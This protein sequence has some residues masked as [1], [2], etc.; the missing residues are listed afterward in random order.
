MEI[1]TTLTRVTLRPMSGDRHR[2]VRLQREYY[3]RTSAGYDDLH[4]AE[5]EPGLELV[6]DCLQRWKAASVLDV[7]TGTGRLLRELAA[8]EPAVAFHG[9]DPVTE[10]LEIAHERYGLPASA[11]SVAG[12]ERLPFDDGSWDAVC[13][14]GVLH[15]VPQPGVVVAEMLRVAAR[16]VVICDDNRFAV[17]ALPRRLAKVALARV[18]VLDRAA[19]VRHGGRDYRFSE[20]DGVSYGFSV[21]DVIAPVREWADE[22]IIHPVGG[23]RSGPLAHRH[24]LGAPGIVLCARRR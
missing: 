18:G 2:A 14:V 7:G 5:F 20:E 8:R 9:V 12:G 3:A 16:V 13:E 22:V 24:M 10:L 6:L 19:R 17:G 11:L 23:P 15:H 4:D 1:A 21:Y